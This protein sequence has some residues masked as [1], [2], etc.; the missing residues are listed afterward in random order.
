MIAQVK[1][2]TKNEKI[3][4]VRTFYLLYLVQKF[5]DAFLPL[6]GEF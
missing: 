2:E 6:D 4:N 3:V 1:K 5:E